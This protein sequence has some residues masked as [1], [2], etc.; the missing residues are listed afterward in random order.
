AD[1]EQQ[2][3]SRCADG[4][5]GIARLV[6]ENSDLVKLL[7]ERDKFIELSGAELQNLRL[8][9]WQLAQANSQMLA[10]LNL[11]KNRVSWCFFGQS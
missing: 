3:G 1:E 6:K 7:E 11:G 4:V 5:D 9:N 10:E 2:D 8:A